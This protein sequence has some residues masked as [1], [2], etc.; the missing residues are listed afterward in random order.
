[1]DVHDWNFINP[2]YIN[3]VSRLK[4][5]TVTRMLTVRNFKIQFLSGLSGL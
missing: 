4:K 3:V 1:M 2:T 5:Q